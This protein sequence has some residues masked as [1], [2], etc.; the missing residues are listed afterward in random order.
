[1]LGAKLRAARLAAGMSQARFGSELGVTFQQVQK[2]ERG[3]NRI[4]AVNLKV[5]SALLGVSVAD[6]LSIDINAQAAKS[7]AASALSDEMDSETAALVAAFRRIESA[8]SRRSV[9][10]VARE[11]SGTGEASAATGAG[12]HLDSAATRRRLSDG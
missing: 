6:L 1:M 4:S 8:R 9:L 7:P 5:A 2:Y 11:F 12:V 10:A 3:S